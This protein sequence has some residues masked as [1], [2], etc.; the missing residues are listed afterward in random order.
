MGATVAIVGDNTLLAQTLVDVLAQRQLAIES[1]LILLPGSIQQVDEHTPLGINP[2]KHFP[3]QEQ[4]INNVDFSQIDI[5]FVISVDDDTE[6]LI[7]QS[8]A[9]GSTV[10]D[11]SGY[12]AS[13]SDIPLILPALN[14]H[15]SPD[16]RPNS[17]I[18]LPS[19]AATLLSRVVFPLAAEFICERITVCHY[20]SASAHGKTGVER[21]AGETARLLNGMPLSKGQ[22]QSAFNL[23]PQSG[24]IDD[25]G[26]TETELGLMRQCERLLGVGNLIV[27]AT[28][29]QVPVF[30][31]QSQAL[32]LQFNQPI[33]VAQATAIL[34]G[35]ADI[36]LVEAYESSPVVAQRQADDE[37][38]V[39]SRLRQNSRDERSLSLWCGSDDLRLGAAVGAV[40][41]AE[42]L[43]KSYL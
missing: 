15:E 3:V 25:K 1:T 6:N 37:R 13:Q 16:L 34:K 27:N 7:G 22:Q 12:S 9:G 5:V 8:L 20:S 38:I 2:P 29:I 33:E 28:C 19:P 43:I 30:Y 26:Y 39:V 32:E 18:A 42:I 40:Q 35:V 21:L 36:D 10:I 23:V 24:A 11:C 17:V 31:G 41:I 14:S 4:F